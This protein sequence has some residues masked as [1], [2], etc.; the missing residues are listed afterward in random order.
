MSDTHGPKT[1]SIRCSPSV[2][3]IRCISK[4]QGTPETI[5][6]DFDLRSSCA[7]FEELDSNENG[8]AM[9]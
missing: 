1:E 9:Q 7:Y 3:W 4:K 2:I 6:E 5:H 8:S